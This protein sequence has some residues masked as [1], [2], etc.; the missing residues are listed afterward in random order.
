MSEQDEKL[1]WHIDQL[2]NRIAGLIHENERLKALLKASE[3]KL[4]RIAFVL[5]IVAGA[6]GWILSAYLEARK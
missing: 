5:L 4:D 2:T 1:M 6:A 3:R